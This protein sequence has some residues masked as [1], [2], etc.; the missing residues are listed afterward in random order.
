MSWWTLQHNRCS[1][2]RWLSENRGSCVWLGGG[3]AA[4]GFRQHPG[5]RQLAAASTSLHE[6]VNIPA[7]SQP[8]ADAE[9]GSSL[10]GGDTLL[11]GGDKGGHEMLARLDQ[12]CL[13]HKV[14]VL[15]DPKL[16]QPIPEPSERTSAA[17]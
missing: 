4:S 17:G 15:R 7:L 10:W 14:P 9:S 5:H 3:K 8:G 1:S 13:D 2:E 16:I 11:Q 12:T 6:E